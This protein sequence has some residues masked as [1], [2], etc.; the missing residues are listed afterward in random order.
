[1]VHLDDPVLLQDDIQL[2][3]SPSLAKL[4][5]IA[6]FLAE[7]ELLMTRLLADV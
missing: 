6:D 7:D 5:S 2:C 4:A 1:M 3:S